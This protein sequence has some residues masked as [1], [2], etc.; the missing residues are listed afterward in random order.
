M[1]EPHGTGVWKSAG[2]EETQREYDRG[3]L[4]REMPLGRNTHSD[5]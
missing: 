2:G 1:D 4:V 5:E 3:D